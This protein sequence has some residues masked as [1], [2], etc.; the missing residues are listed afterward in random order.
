MGAFV[1]VIFWII[2]SALV[3]F[4]YIDA[5]QSAGENKLIVCLIFFI[6]GPIFAASDLLQRILDIFLPEGWNSND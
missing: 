4:E 2:I 1:I 5:I 3:M 6:G